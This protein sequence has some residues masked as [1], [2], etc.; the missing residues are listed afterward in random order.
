[1]GMMLWEKN[2]N[3]P[4]FSHTYAKVRKNGRDERPS[5]NAG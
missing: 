2:T 3:L 5:F 4:F 1:M